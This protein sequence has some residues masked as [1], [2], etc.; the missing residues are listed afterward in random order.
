[1]REHE[2]DTTSYWQTEVEIGEAPFQGRPTRLHLRVHSGD[3]QYHHT[4]DL[5]TLSQP[6]GMR[7]YFHARPYI[8]IPHITLTAE[9]FT[10][11]ARDGA[12]GEVVATEFEGM[13]PQD[14]GDAQAWYY[15]SDRTLILWECYLYEWGRLPNSRDDVMQATLWRGFEQFL[16]MCLPEAERIVTPAWEPIYEV[17]DWRD[18]LRSQAYAP[19]S[20][21]AFVKS[22]ERK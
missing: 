13:R 12:I 1:M 19:L 10:A 3:E 2:Q 7:A 9:F 17:V 8:L 5:V 18:F 11:P 15:P 21:R 14:I 4:A 20:D 6:R 22:V 16:L